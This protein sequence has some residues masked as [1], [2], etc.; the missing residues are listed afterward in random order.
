MSSTTGAVSVAPTLSLAENEAIIERGLTSFVEVGKALMRIRDDRQYRKTHPTFEAY[1]RARWDFTPQ[2]A[3]QLIA[4]AN[5]VTEMETNVSTPP[6]PSEAVARELKGTPEQKAEAWRETVKRHGSKPTAAQTRSVMQELLPPAKRPRPRQRNEEGDDLWKDERVLA[7]AQKA[8]K[9]RRG[10][11]ERLMADSKAGKYDWP[12]SGKHLAQNAADR[13][14]AILGDRERHQRGA[15]PKAA[16]KPKATEGGKRVRQL[17]ADKRAGQ[18][19]AESD[20]FKMQVALAESIGYLERFDLPDL[21]WSEDVQELLN[22]I[23]HDLE[24]HRAWNERAWDTI[25]AKMDDVGRQRRMRELRMRAD[26]QT[27]GGEWEAR[28]AR[29]L[30]ERLEKKYHDQKQ[31]G[32]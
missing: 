6:P 20:V 23:V 27:P 3:G 22:D 5:T 26:D 1:C 19:D 30:L 29:E 15:P 9:A 31:V 2:R 21:D 16:K 18:R 13:V 7:W 11:R 8:K 17:H 12:V 14:L 10:T 25:W 4:A 32:A 24:R 28:N